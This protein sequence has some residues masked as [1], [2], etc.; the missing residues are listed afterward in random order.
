[1]GF[2]AGFESFFKNVG[3]T[4]ALDAT[5]SL[6]NGPKP[7]KAQALKNKSFRSDAYGTDWSRFR[8]WVRAQGKDLWGTAI[9]TSIWKT[10]SGGFFGLGATSIYYN[11][12]SE[13]RFVGFGE[14][15]GGGAAIRFLRVYADGKILF[16]GVASTGAVAG[17]TVTVVG[18]GQQ[19]GNQFVLIDVASGGALTLN[20]GDLII[21][22]TDPAPYTVQSTVTATGPTSSVSVSIWPPLRQTFAGGSAVT[23]SQQSISPYDLSSFDPNP[24]DGSHTAGGYPCPPGGMAFYLG[25]DTQM[26]DPTMVKHLGA[27]N[28]PGYRGRT[29]V[30]LRDLQL[31]NHGD[32]RPAITAEIAYDVASP[33]YPM[34]GPIPDA[35]LFGG[36]LDFDRI[37]LSFSGDGG[38][39][40][41]NPLTQRLPYVWVLSAVGQDATYDGTIYRFNT[42][43]HLV[44]ASTLLLRQG[45][46][47]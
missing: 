28:V 15:L 24:H 31:S 4:L 32:H 47:G 42:T 12:Y 1:M 30:L 16:N 41:F 7:Q 46:F 10:V 14:K 25:G 6:L 20:A 8:G 27:G 34:I 3:L 37:A 21:V 9:Q 18:G 36:G 5:A 38:L 33:L 11:K 43:T 29:G 40:F 17:S 19:Q 39:T 26:P 2:L 23:L 45:T 35:P 22:G 13:S 44:E